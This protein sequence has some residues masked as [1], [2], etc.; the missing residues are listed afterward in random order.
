MTDDDEF[1]E[2]FYIGKNVHFK[3]G[4]TGIITDVMFNNIPCCAYL[5][6]LSIKLGDYTLV[7][8]STKLTF[9]GTSFYEK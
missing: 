8:E 7:M 3:N 5:I 4:I 6:S 1:T 9:D 2:E